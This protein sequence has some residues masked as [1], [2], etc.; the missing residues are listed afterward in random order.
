M[1]QVPLKWLINILTEKWC[2]FPNLETHK[3]YN[4]HVLSILIFTIK[5]ST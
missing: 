5:A 2:E 4:I 1:S 3:Y